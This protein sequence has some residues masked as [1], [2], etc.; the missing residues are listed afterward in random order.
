MPG[1]WPGIWQLVQCVVED[2]YDVLTHSDLPRLADLSI[3]GRREF[4]ISSWGGAASNAMERSTDSIR[5][6]PWKSS[7]FDIQGGHAGDCL[8]GSFL[9]DQE[10]WISPS[11]RRR[12]AEGSRMHCVFERWPAANKLHFSFWIFSS[13][14]IFWGSCGSP[15]QKSHFYS[16]IFY[17][18]KIQHSPPIATSFTVDLWL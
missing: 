2:L 8:R 16:L 9:L 18:K 7:L 11:K 6:V 1:V 3:A 12:R 4:W 5:E 10:A 17:E 14:K 15:Y 13:T